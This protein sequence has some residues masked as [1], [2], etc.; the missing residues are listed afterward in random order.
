MKLVN[1]QCDNFFNGSRKHQNDKKEQILKYYEIKH[2][3]GRNNNSHRVT[4][5]VF[6]LI[7]TQIGDARIDMFYI[8]LVIMKIF[9]AC[10]NAY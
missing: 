6:N 10:N 9:F 3:E 4:H 7:K 2:P 8:R 5:F 1:S